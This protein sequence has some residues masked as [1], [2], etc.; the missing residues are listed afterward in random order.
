[1]KRAIKNHL[2]DFVALAV[3]FLIGLG[4]SAYILGHQRL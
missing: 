2:R 4:V 1:M 3:L